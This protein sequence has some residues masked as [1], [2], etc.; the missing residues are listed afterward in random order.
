MPVARPAGS[1]SAAERHHPNSMSSPSA[2]ASSTL[3]TPTDDGSNNPP[4][5]GPLPP[6]SL[7]YQV[8]W[9]LVLVLCIIITGLIVV[10]SRARRRY[11]AALRA[12]DDDYAGFE[13]TGQALRQGSR[14]AALPRPVLSDIWI[15][16]YS[17]P[18]SRS[19]SWSDI[20]VGFLHLG[21]S[22]ILIH[23][24]SRCRRNTWIPLRRP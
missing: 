6:S 7:L 4:N 1:D 3:P 22:F 18:E 23:S 12:A 15:A 17:V 9:T 8:V 13:D 21:G 24:R 16:K 5:S 14:Y 11:L 2:S 10:R 19:T 20:M